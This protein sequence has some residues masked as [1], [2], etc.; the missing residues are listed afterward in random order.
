MAAILKQIKDGRKF[1]DEDHLRGHACTTIRGAIIDFIVREQRRAT[2][3]EI[4]DRGVIPESNVWEL[5]PD[6]FFETQEERQLLT[7]RLQ[8]Y[9][10]KEIAE[11]IG[12]TRSY[13]QALRRQIGIRYVE[14]QRGL[15]N[16]VHRSD[17]ESAAG[18]D[19]PSVHG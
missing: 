19:D 10:D 14:Y 11:S 1:V 17:D 8:G 4:P 6:H 15:G 3:S 12:R 9:T 13:I 7:L 2:Y 16:Q 5:I 18:R